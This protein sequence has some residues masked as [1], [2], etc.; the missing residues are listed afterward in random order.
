MTHENDSTYSRSRF[1]GGAAKLGAAGALGAGAL[2][3]LLG[4]SQAAAA[5]KSKKIAVIEQAFGTFF[6][7]NFNKP[8]SAFIKKNPG[9]SVTFG[10]ENNT[11]TTGINLLNQYVSQDYGVLILST[12][13][14]MSAWENSV[15]KA[16]ASG[17]VFINHCTQA[18]SGATQ[19][20]LFSHKQSGV[21]VGNASVAWAKKNNIAQPVVAL[22]GN[23]SDAQGKKRTDWA[24]KTIKAK[25][26]NAKLAGQA[27]GIGTTDGG[28]AAANLLAAHPDIN[29]LITFNTLAGL[30]ALTS[31]M[32]AG[33]TDRN[34]FLLATA[35][36]EDA[37]LKLI[38]DGNSI[39]QINWGAFFPASMIMMLK[40]AMKLDAGKK[41]PPTRLI[42][43]LTIVTPKQAKSFDTITFDPL[44]PKYSY[45]F[46]K[47]FKYLDT[48]VKTAQVPP[49]Q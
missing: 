5:V 39:Y 23:L 22:I 31:A 9:W 25:L 15:K 24:W 47:Y 48:P 36:S 2:P 12:G 14:N 18:V 45:V 8:A 10:N 7:V 37:S 29:M 17:A 40:D 35:D 1:L 16:V 26:P 33:K 3:A 49:G 30:S 44:N 34:K 42:Y 4:A 28:K 41:I 20:V 32:H 11:V 21:D 43:G 38:A 6:T 46:N 27:Q 13:D 19:N